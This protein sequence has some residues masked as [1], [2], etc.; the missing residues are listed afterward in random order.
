MPLIDMGQAPD[1]EPIPAGWYDCVLSEW[2]Y[3][4]E[5]ESS[6]EPYIKWTFAVDEGEHEGA[7]LFRNSSCQVKALPYLKRILLA[8]GADPDEVSGEFD[9]DEIIP[10]LVGNPCRIKVGIRDYEGS[11]TNEVQRVTAST[12]SV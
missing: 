6:G 2:E 12:V 5:S 10:D 7:K 9:T 11:P 8:L 1:Y 4:E 3:V